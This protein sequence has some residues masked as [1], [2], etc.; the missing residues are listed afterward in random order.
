M[1]RKPLISNLES[2]GI[3]VVYSLKLA[4]FIFTLQAEE[5]IKLPP[6][7]GS[8][9]RGAMGR[10]FKQLS[11]LTRQGRCEL[12]MFLPRCAYAYIFETSVKTISGDFVQ[13]YIP[14]PFLIEPP[15]DGKTDYDEGDE[16]EFGLLLMGRGL[17][18]LPF[19]IASF[20][21]AA[22]R[23]LGAARGCFKLKGVDQF[24]G[25]VR[26]R[27]WSGGCVLL[28]E[29]EQEELVS[30]VE[31]GIDQSWQKEKGVNSITLELQTPTRFFKDGDMNVR[32]DFS[33][34]MRSIFRRLDLL[35]R[36][37]G[38][39]PLVLP[40]RDLLVQAMS[41]KTL[42]YNLLWYDWTRYSARQRKNVPI[43]GLAGSIAF[44]GELKSFLPFIN[45]ARIVHVGKGTVYGLGKITVV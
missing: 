41:V 45:M 23:G 39:G 9:L 14:H 30:F 22:Q 18:Y 37:H 17:D 12:C 24:R 33:L 42:E 7:K 44:G 3:Q 20:E 16:L 36:A 25:G 35:G 6:F 27:L 26:Y 38:D 10:A 5:R 19:F 15:L 4:R 40:F 29:L 1:Y 8:T 2:C 31:S 21:Q 13:H 32:L 34:L 11:C 28:N 43:G